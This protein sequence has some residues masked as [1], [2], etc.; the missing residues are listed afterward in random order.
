MVCNHI[1][2]CSVLFCDNVD[3]LNPPRVLGGWNYTKKIKNKKIK[4]K[5]LKNEYRSMRYHLNHNRIALPLPSFKKP[6]PRKTNNTLTYTKTI[7]VQLKKSFRKRWGPN[8][9]S[10]QK[11][12]ETLV[13][14]VLFFFVFTL[15]FLFYE[16]YIWLEER[17]N[18]KRSNTHT[19][20]H[21]HNTN[22]CCLDIVDTTICQNRLMHSI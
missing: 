13:S 11:G 18:K 1:S 15:N 12:I 8:I 3:S 7:D 16:V 22:L 9:D 4:I 10:A 6:L 2:K 20:T 21:T 19:H 14:Y 5:K 17:K